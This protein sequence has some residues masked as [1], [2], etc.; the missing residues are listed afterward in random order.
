MK[1][2]IFAG[3]APAQFR[4]GFDFVENEQRAVL[5]AYLAQAFQKTG[6]RHAEAHVHENRLENNRGN[7]AGILFE[8]PLDRGQI[9]ERGDLYVGDGRLG[10]AETASDRGWIV[11]VAV[12]GRVRLH[13]DQ[14][15]VMQA[16]VG[17]FELHNLVASSSSARQANRVHGDFGAAVSEAA[18][19]DREAGADLFREFPLHVVRHAEHGAS[20]EPSSRPLSS[21]R[22][23]SVRP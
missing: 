9:I 1:A 5:V 10:H 22:D 12:V 19:L 18:H 6:P 20:G 23:G 17:A 3:A 4:A 8:P 15:A 7:L 11:D 14:R 2:K 16:V 13:A 21:R